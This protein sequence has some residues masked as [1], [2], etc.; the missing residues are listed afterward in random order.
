[1][2]F[3]TAK[4]RTRQLSD[5]VGGRPGAPKKKKKKEHDE[6]DHKKEEKTHDEEIEGKPWYIG[7]HFKH[8]TDLVTNLPL[9]FGTFE[10]PP[11]NEV[12]C[13]QLYSNQHPSCCALHVHTLP[14]AITDRADEA[15]FKG[16]EET[17]QK[18][19]QKCPIEMIGQ[20][21]NVGKKVAKKFAMKKYTRVTSDEV[22]PKVCNV[23]FHK[24][25]A[26][27]PRG[28]AVLLQALNWYLV[29][30][31]ATWEGS[32]LECFS[33]GEI[34]SVVEFKEEDRMDEDVLVCYCSLE[35]HT[36]AG[37]EPNK[38]QVNINEFKTI[39]RKKATKCPPDRKWPGLEKDV[40]GS[41]GPVKGLDWHKVSGNYQRKNPDK[42]WR[43]R[44]S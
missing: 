42:R 4:K 23:R 5:R 40:N 15:A 7:S 22:R 14:V 36:Q 25:I 29:E 26:A 43:P 16:I 1:M 10:I 24:C 19:R 17:R 34:R 6:D 32:Y 20:Y 41:Q 30:V 31:F 35:E 44:R 2:H 33:D 21:M 11:G 38:V 9:F 27:D 28:A 12:F 37:N 13:P 3:T 8:L 39:L 18:F